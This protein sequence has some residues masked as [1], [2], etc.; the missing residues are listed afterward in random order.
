MRFL[1]VFRFLI[2]NKLAKAGCIGLKLSLQRAGAT[3]GEKEVTGDS[4]VCDKTGNP[5]C[6]Q[7]DDRDERTP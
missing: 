2:S 6:E 5:V 1:F 4:A 3:G 7:N